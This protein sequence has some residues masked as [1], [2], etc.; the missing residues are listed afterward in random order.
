MKTT[1]RLPYSTPARRSFAAAFAATVFACGNAFA[2]PPMP[3]HYQV[4]F[5]RTWSSKTHP[6]DFP[7]LAHF[8]PVIG[9]TH[10]EGYSPFHEGGTASPGLKRLCEEGTHQ[11]L[12]DEIRAAIAAKTAGALIETPDP[13]RD[14]PAKAVAS[15]EIDPAH[16]MVS[17]A[18]MIAPSPD[19]CAMT[20]DVMLLEN[21]QWVANKTVTLYAWDAGTDSGTS[22]RA[23]DKETE[24]RGTIQLSDA[25][26]FL[27]KDKTRIPV[28]QVTFVRQ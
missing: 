14:V 15:F 19:W 2:E 13:I 20:A 9:V 11:P 16:P 4:S 6:K 8:S 24:P 5:E 23:F 12:D 3:A 17:I 28:G 26:Y 21:G 1:I 25:P 10:G 27:K 18:A 7:I 22:Y